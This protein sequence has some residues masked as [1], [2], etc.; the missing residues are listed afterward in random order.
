MLLSI[1]VLHKPQTLTLFGPNFFRYCTKKKSR[2]TPQL[3]F[4]S[5][6]KVDLLII[7]KKIFE[8]SFTSRFL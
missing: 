7:N 6:M 3:P 2:E 1:K 8:I 5:K 4:H